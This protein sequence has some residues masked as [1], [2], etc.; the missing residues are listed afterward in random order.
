MSSWS[1]GTTCGRSAR[2]GSSPATVSSYSGWTRT[3]CAHGF[4]RAAADLE[5]RALRLVREHDA[6]V[7]S[8]Y[9]KGTLTPALV[10]RIVAECRARGIPCIIDPKKVDFTVF[11]GAT[12]LTPNL[13]EARRAWAGRSRT[14]PRSA[15]R[16]KRRGRPSAWNTC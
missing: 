5:E 15:R 4:E 8:D 2:P 13:L 3:A 16:P 14:R 11:S 7:L 6:V 9:D 10:R 1:S 12:L